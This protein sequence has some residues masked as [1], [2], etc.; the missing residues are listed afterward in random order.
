MNVQMS[1]VRRLP[2]YVHVIKVECLN[3]SPKT[4]TP[5]DLELIQ[6][7]AIFRAP[8]YN[9]LY[10]WPRQHALAPGL[11]IRP[12][13]NIYAKESKHPGHSIWKI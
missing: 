6:I 1:W 5:Y 12:I 7:M 8:S 9:S 11:N 2:S 4:N 10:R 13:L 3:R